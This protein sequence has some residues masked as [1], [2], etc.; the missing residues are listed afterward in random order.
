VRRGLDNLPKPDGTRPKEERLS[1]ETYKFLRT[2]MKEAPHPD[3][4]EIIDRIEDKISEIEQD[5]FSGCT[6]AINRF[7]DSVS[8]INPDG[9]KSRD[10][11][12]LTGQDC[13]EVLWAL[14][15]DLIRAND[16]VSKMF[17]IAQMAYNL[18]DDVYYEFYKK[19]IEGTQNDRM[20]HA[21]KYSK[22]ERYYYM[23][24]YWVHKRVKD[25]LDSI[26]QIKRDIE[27]TLQRRVSDR[28]R[29]Y[30]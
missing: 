4:Q 19:P 21:K 8:V 17:N 27:Q 6:E 20:A 7:Y 10:W 18:W 13:E 3:E 28:N 26:K 11:N 12:S 16:E 9:T 25:K 1:I 29:V 22:E 2:S 30:E 5:L 23:Y 15:Y 24:T 14:N